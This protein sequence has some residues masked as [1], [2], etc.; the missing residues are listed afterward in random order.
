MDAKTALRAFWQLGGVIRIAGLQVLSLIFISYSA[1]LLAMAKGVRGCPP[2]PELLSLYFWVSAAFGIGFF[3]IALY[4]IAFPSI[5]MQAI[6]RVLAL[7]PI[8]VHLPFFSTHPIYV[9]IDALFFIPAIALFQGGRAETMCRLNNEW[10]TGWALLLLAFFFPLFRVF[11]WTVLGRQIEA[12][13]IKRPLLVI[14]WWYVL[15]LPVLLYST[16]TYLDKQ[17]WPRLRV[18]V[19]NSNTYQGGIDRHPELTGQIVRVQGVLVRGMAK[20]GLFGKDETKFPFPFGTVV[21]EMGKKNGQIMIQA[22]SPREVKKLEIEAANREGMI[23]ESF[24][25]L[26][27]LPNLKK[28]MICGIGK[29]DKKQ[30]GGLGLL[31]IEMP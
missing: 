31:E 30:K 4:Y 27:K 12:M 3:L 1:G 25:R 6:N 22:R 7:S 11:C 28:R 16:H 24:G 2:Q 17:V 26:S 18:P 21:L 19:V 14:S 20:C 10:A 9:F 29:A 5:W 13:K 8:E 15:A 23:I